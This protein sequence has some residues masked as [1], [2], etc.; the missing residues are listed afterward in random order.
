MNTLLYARVSTDRQAQKDLSIPAQL[1]AMKDFAKNKGLKI[2]DTYI[3]AGE[4]AKTINRPE[5]KRLMKYC[6]EHGDQVDAVMVHKIDRLARNLVDHATIKALLKQKN[7]RLISVVENCEDSI[8]G[9]LVEN[10]MASIAEFYSANL[11]EEVKKGINSKLKNGGW[12]AK[13]PLGYKNINNKQGKPYPVEN[14]ETAPL[15][16]QTFELYSSGNYSLAALSEE[17]YERGLKTRYDNKFSKERI[18][19]ILINNFYIGRM[20]WR[21]KE[22]SGTHKPLISERLFY[23]VQENMRKRHKDTGEKGRYS[24]LLRGVAYCQTCGEKLTAEVHA[25]GSYYSCIR[26]HQKDKCTEP[27]SPI[28]NIEDQLEVLY[29]KMQPPIEVLELIKEE[30]EGIVQ[31]RQQVAKTEL[32]SLQQKMSKIEEK[33]LKLA[34]ELVERD[35]SRDVFKKLQQKITAEKNAVQERLSQL[36]VDYQ[37]PLDFLDKCIV[38]ASSLYHLH[39]KFDSKQ[40]KKLLLAVFERIE[41]KNREIAYVKLNPPF[42]FLFEEEIGE[43]FK[44]VPECRRNRTNFEQ[45]ID[46][47]VAFTLSPKFTEINAIIAQLPI[48]NRVDRNVASIR[49]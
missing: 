1:S 32:T 48:K 47:L 4:S 24:F 10:I 3:D 12:P 29:E 28:K 30:L 40:Q 45:L 7:I 19:N 33:E 15:I 35:I 14:P 13:A 8:T 6:K 43:M 37:E 27:Y 36:K 42:S 20:V 17:M 25:R 41:I 5:L 26:N 31:K 22:Y 9:Q 46:N 49:K 2:I 21:D 16:R 38:V 11:G 23:Q 44:V 34:D 39:Q 18:K